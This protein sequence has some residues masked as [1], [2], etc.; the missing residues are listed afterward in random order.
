MPL[1]SVSH[2]FKAN[3]KIKCEQISH[4]IHKGN[5]IFEKVKQPNRMSQIPH[6]HGNIL[7]APDVLCLEYYMRKE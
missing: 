6:Y 5:C 4:L 3:V 7:S 2:D 1:F